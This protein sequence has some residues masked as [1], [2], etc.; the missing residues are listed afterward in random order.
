MD[1]EVVAVAEQLA[2]EFADLPGRYVVSAV[3]HCRDD[4]PAGGSHFIE[5]AARA[6]LVEAQHGLGR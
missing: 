5:Q 4:F 3:E 2:N 6:R 1:V